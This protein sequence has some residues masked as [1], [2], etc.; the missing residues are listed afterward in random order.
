MKARMASMVLAAA[1]AAVGCGDDDDNPMAG[2][3]G[4]AGSGGSTGT[5]GM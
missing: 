2:T 4:M 1:L 3:G 5:G